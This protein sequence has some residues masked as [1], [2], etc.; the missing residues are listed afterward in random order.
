MT[1]DGNLPLTPPSQSSL[2]NLLGAGDKAPTSFSDYLKNSIESVDR[3][4]KG[5]ETEIAKAV[6]GDSEDLHK[7]VISLQSAELNFQL[8]LQIRNKFVNAFEEIMRMPV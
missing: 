1:I 2:L 3:T 7:T 8:A 5:A 6:T 4:Q